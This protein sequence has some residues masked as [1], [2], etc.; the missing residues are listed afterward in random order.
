MSRQID[1]NAM[2]TTP[3]RIRGRLADAEDILPGGSRHEERNRGRQGWGAMDNRMDQG[4]SS[5]AI[6][7]EKSDTSHEIAG[8]QNATI[9][10]QPQDPRALGRGTLTKITIMRPEA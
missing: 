1:P 7:A 2:D 5:P 4:K 8:S 6:T 3:D 10:R 9:T